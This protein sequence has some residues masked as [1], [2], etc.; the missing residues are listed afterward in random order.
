MATFQ[1]ALQDIMLGG[2]WRRPN[3]WTGQEKYTWYTKRENDPVECIR[4][5][6]AMPNILLKSH[7]GIEPCGNETA[8]LFLS[9]YFADD[10][11]KCGQWDE[12]AVIL[13]DRK[14]PVRT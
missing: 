11:E 13:F 1:E 5:S 2:W 12:E 9:D 3:W 6:T 8:A 14:K 4:R 10:W 7:P